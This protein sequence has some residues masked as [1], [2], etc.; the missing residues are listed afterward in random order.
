MSLTA[1]T[2]QRDSQ[3]VQ[4]WLARLAA[5]DCGEIA[6]TPFATGDANSLRRVLGDEDLQVTARC[7]YLGCQGLFCGHAEDLLETEADVLQCFA[8]L[9]GE[10]LAEGF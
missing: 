3:R 9:D 5:E 7:C 6:S 4:A 8:I 10:F 2:G 1:P